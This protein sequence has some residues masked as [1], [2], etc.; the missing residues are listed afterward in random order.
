MAAD[1]VGMAVQERACSSQCPAPGA[2]AVAAS[3]AASA[4]V[5]AAAVGPGASPAAHARAL[6][7]ISEEEG[8][9]GEEGV[10]SRPEAGSTA[11][12]VGGVVDLGPAAEDQEG[13]RIVELLLRFDPSRLRAEFQSL[14]MH[15]MHY[16]AVQQPSAAADRQGEPVVAPEIDSQSRL[17]AARL[18]ERQKGQS[19]RPLVSHADVLLW[20]HSRA[21]AKKEERRAQAKSEEVSGCTFQPKCSPRA[22][23]MQG[24]VMTP[25]GVTRAQVLYARA[26]A[27]RERREARAQEDA[28]AR[29][30]AEVRDC[31]FR[32]DT[33]K[34]AH[35]FH[36]RAHEA[37]HVPR[38]FYEA[39]RR[40][41]DAGEVE[42]QRRQQRED[43]NARPL[44]VNHG[45]A[46]ASSAAAQSSRAAGGS[47]GSTSGA[48]ADLHGSTGCGPMPMDQ[49][50]PGR[51]QQRGGARESGGANSGSASPP[52][53]QGQD[54]RGVRA[55]SQSPA[56]ALHEAPPGGR[57]SS[58]PHC[59]GP[60]G[61]CGGGPPR[62]GVPGSPCLGGVEGRCSFG[63]GTGGEEL[64]GDGREDAMP[65]PLLYVDVNIAPGQPPERIVLREGQSVNEVAAEFAA[66]HV[67]PPVLAQ[68][69]HALL[70]EVL[71]RQEQHLSQQHLR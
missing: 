33:A 21:Q 32:P 31:T 25:R 59:A 68:R 47:A 37:A 70:K 10:D 24:E 22:H 67:L 17:M 2:A 1:A 18:T 28:R 15:R 48:G 14:Y 35:S 36:H 54:S 69:L 56:G 71:Q 26:L 16:Q 3:N 46:S 19:D 66:R 45:N 30:D 57:P 53:G 58:P 23:D 41:R 11:T 65:A 12:L 27:D 6:A 42:R 34:S 7:A 13:R 5:A 9:S 38:G 51:E 43:R 63:E 55:R 29:S 8:A 61:A 44:P 52:M 39:Q 4:A 20:R 49:G 64:R 40:L 60:G 50:R 62:E